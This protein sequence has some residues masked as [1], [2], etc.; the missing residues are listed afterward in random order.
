MKISLQMISRVSGSPTEYKNCSNKSNQIKEE[1]E[2]EK[3]DPNE[4][5]IYEPWDGIFK[6]LYQIKS[7]II[8]LLLENMIA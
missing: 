4:L 7:K 5:L 6:K 8:L 3:I 2:N 1:L